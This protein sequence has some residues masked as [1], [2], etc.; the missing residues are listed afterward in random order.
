M[1]KTK[2]SQ[3]EIDQNLRMVSHLKAWL[4]AKKCTQEHIANELGVSHGTVSKWLRGYQAMNL[5]QFSAVAALLGVAEEKLLFAPEQAEDAQSY[6]EA[7]RIIQALNPAKL[8]RW[9]DLGIDLAEL[10]DKKVSSE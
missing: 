1:S 4:R 6:L 3:A 9:L 10:D 5:S 7:G 2:L 8:R